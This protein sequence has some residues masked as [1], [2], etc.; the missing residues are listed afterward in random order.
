MSS[1]TP[2]SGPE[3]PTVSLNHVALTVRN[4][5]AAVDWY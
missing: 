1:D 4:L 2:R 3:S 5:E